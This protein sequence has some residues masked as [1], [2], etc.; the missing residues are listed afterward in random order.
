MRKSTSNSIDYKQK[1]KNNALIY[2]LY[3]ISINDTF[4]EKTT[5]IYI[6]YEEYH[7]INT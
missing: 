2:N 5:N 3:H 6:F 7:I 1:H 4:P